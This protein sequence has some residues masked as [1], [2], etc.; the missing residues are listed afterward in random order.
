MRRHCLKCIHFRNEGKFKAAFGGLTSLSS[1]CGSL[2]GDNGI[3]LIHDRY[4]LYRRGAYARSKL[5]RPLPE[6]QKILKSAHQLEV[7]LESRAKEC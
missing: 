7:A 2:L 5:V 3:C 6:T 4:M 1:G